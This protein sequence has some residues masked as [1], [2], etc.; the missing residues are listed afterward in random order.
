MSLIG[1]LEFKTVI[2]DQPV[3]IKIPNAHLY[4]ID[5][6]VENGHKEITF[7]VTAIKDIE[8]EH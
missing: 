3:I 8:E 6:L 2:D 1:D 4:D 5:V 7:F